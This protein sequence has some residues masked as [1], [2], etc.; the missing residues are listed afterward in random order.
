MDSPALLLHLPRGTGA[1]RY[2]PGV[3]SSSGGTRPEPVPS[4]PE[5]PEDAEDAEERMA[6]ARVEAEQAEQEL[7]FHFA[8][9]Q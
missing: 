7:G 6:L 1:I 5:Q 8:F 2:A 9:I 3:A 4:Q